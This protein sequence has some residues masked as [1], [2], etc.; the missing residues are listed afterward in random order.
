MRY[1]HQARQ[2][3]DRFRPLFLLANWRPPPD[4]KTERARRNFGEWLPAFRQALRKSGWS[5]PAEGESSSAD[6]AYWQ[7]RGG[8]KNLLQ[9][10]G[11]V[12][13]PRLR[14]LAE[15]QRAVLSMLPRPERVKNALI[16][17]DAKGVRLEPDPGDLGALLWMLQAELEAG[18]HRVKAC[19]APACGRFLG[20]WTKRQRLFCD[21]TCRARFHNARKAKARRRG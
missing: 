13:A 14:L 6:W 21:E 10:R 4:L 19:R 3:E 9:H 1:R 11:V 16:V 17:T 7:L 2:L 12:I 20:Q 15:G 5:V 8:Y 18:R